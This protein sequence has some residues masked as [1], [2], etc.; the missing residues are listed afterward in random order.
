MQE[1]INYYYSFEFISLTHSL[2][3]NSIQSLGSLGSHDQIRYPTNSL[4]LKDNNTTS[5]KKISYF[6]AK[7]KFVLFFILFFWV[8]YYF[9]IFELFD[10]DAVLK[11]MHDAKY[12]DDINYSIVVSLFI[13]LFFR[14]FLKR[15]FFNQTNQIDKVVKI[16]EFG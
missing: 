8:F 10:F 13:S 14:A 1:F 6:V 12:I 15:I 3:K 9:Y 7:F 11:F 2:F 5:K 16:G 4:H